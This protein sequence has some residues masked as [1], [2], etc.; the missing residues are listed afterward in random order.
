M[1]IFEGDNEISMA[2]LLCVS[3]SCSTGAEALAGPHSFTSGPYPPPMF[4]FSPGYEP[5][6]VGEPMAPQP[7]LMSG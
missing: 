1:D 5:P 6:F 4:Y 3:V 2:D 7:C